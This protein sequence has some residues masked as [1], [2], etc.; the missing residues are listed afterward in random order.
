MG[1]TFIRPYRI[2]P[3]DIGGDI[4][5]SEVESFAAKYNELHPESP[6][7]VQ[8]IDKFQQK[9]SD[10]LLGGFIVSE[11][12]LLFLFSFGIGVFS[13]QDDDFCFD[14]T[15]SKYA[16][17]YCESRKIA[18]DNILKG[19]AK[20]SKLLTGLAGFIRKQYRMTRKSARISA[21]PDWE[22][23]GFS[24]V[25]T[26]SYVNTDLDG[27]D[28]TKLS[29]VEKHSLQILLRPSLAHEEDS[30]I[31]GLID[32]TKQTD[33]YQI[34]LNTLTAPKDCWKSTSA[35]IYIS[36]AAVLVMQKEIGKGYIGMMNSLEV[37]LQAMWLYTYCLYCN[38]R[39]GYGKKSPL[40]SELKHLANEYE[41][42]YNEF[43]DNGDS[44]SPQY[45]DDIRKE[46][47]GTSKI[48]EEHDKF[49]EHMKVCIDETETLEREHHRKY[50][51]LNE[52]LLF[53]IAYAD[54]LTTLA[55]NFMGTADLA[56][57]IAFI[58]ISVTV[59]LAGVWF[60]IGKG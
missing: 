12:I 50:G 55:T 58:I 17:D 15:C 57:V 27:Y 56:W 34:D 1:N 38:S 59:F 42:Q 53:I 9:L 37:D 30:E 51:W 52:I 32:P 7:R 31:I 5:K 40:A 25:M 47:I 20:Y 2:I 14:G 4:S 3:F 8:P 49:L 29:D 18:H 22:N 39:T 13:V 44:S 26:V 46:L 23:H 36:W 60:I 24:Y 43:L 16:V 41:R 6:V 48:Q 54:I 33:P 10:C 28:Y 21:S 11:K 45:V 19:T 35:D